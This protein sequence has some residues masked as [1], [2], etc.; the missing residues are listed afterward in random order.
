MAAEA[1]LSIVAV[2]PAYTS[3]WGGRHWQ[4]PL[5]TPRREMSRHDAAAIA[6]GRRALGHPIRRR[7][8]PPPP[9]Q[10]DRVGHRTV[11]AEP[12]LPGREETR[13]PATERAHDARPRTGTTRGTR[14]TSASNTVRDARNAGTWVQHPLL[15]IDEERCGGSAMAGG[16]SG[17]ELHAVHADVGGPVWAG[18]MWLVRGNLMGGGRGRQ[19]FRCGPPG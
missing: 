16:P 13:P 9:D 11:Q 1:G 12:G 7:T 17:V 6:I 8:A 5:L 15:I 14:E 2:D 18:W 19:S 10:S 4:K 3:Q